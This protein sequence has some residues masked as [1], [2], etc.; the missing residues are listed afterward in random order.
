MNPSLSHPEAEEQ[1]SRWAAR[2]DGG[3]LDAAARRE[4]E[5]WLGRAPDH[6]QLLSRYCQL[7][8]DLEQV[9]VPA[10]TDSE[11]AMT[12]PATGASLSRP[13]RRR[14]LAVAAGLAALVAVALVLRN[15]TP[16]AREIATAAG[17]R[18]T[19]T[20]EDG[21]QVELNAGT[22]LEF[23]D[24]GTERRARLSEGEVFFSVSHDAS[25]PF[26]VETPAGSVRVTGT[27]FNVRSESPASVEVVVAE[28]SVEM[29]ALPPP[30]G[31]ASRVVSL[32]AGSRGF[33]HDGRLE[34][35]A[36]PAGALA[37]ALAWREGEIV[38]NG[39]TLQEALQR[40]GRYHGRR[41]EVSADAAGQHPGGRMKLADF[42]GFLENISRAEG[43]LGVRVTR[44]PDLIRVRLLREP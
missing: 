5:A 31:G 39:L 42:D 37:A 41:I 3:P 25:R 36:L 35:E 14:W 18:Q 29:S 15:P 19:V 28:G 34:R 44:E 20:L 32:G 27:Q 4:L 38:L 10:A 30:G 16:A 17:T 33:V 26:F 13:R 23:R 7:S 24:V 2:L 21:T 8:A 40:F 12:P 6:R 1:A 11:R 22:R 9:L 43:G